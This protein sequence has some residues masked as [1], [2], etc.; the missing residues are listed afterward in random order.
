MG[1]LPTKVRTVWRNS[2][3]NEHEARKSTNVNHEDFEFV[4][5]HSSHGIKHFTSLTLSNLKFVAVPALA[6]IETLDKRYRQ[7]LKPLEFC[8]TSVGDLSFS[9]SEILLSSCWLE[10]P[11][12]MLKKW[13]LITPRSKIYEVAML[14]MVMYWS[15]RAITT[16]STL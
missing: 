7:P 13:H 10:P 2:H 15:F 5:F 14:K 11:M 8:N 9:H 4:S 12:E 16:I 6:R 3:L 1:V